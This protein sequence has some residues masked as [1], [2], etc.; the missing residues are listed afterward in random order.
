KG[1]ELA[2]KQIKTF[3]EILLDAYVHVSATSGSTVTTSTTAPF[4]QKLMMFCIYLLNGFGLVGNS[5]GSIFSMRSDLKVK[6]AI[7]AK[8]I[9]FYA[10]E[11]IKIMIKNG[12][13]EEPPQ[14]ED[15]SVK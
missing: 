6:Q 10:N 5:F 11:G 13:M 12:W 14:M 8:D 2:K 9:F 3:E 4:S 15:R 1:K 7:V